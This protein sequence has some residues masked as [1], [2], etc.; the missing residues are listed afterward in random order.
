MPT[1]IRMAEHRATPGFVHFT[2]AELS[3]LLDLYAR[4]VAGGEWRDYAIDLGPERAV[5]SI[6]RHTLDRP[7]YA[8]AKLGAAADAPEP[9]RGDYVVTDSERE[10][11]RSANLSE[12]LAVLERKPRLVMP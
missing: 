10:L 11:A 4:R 9:R 1:L 6:Y 2:R 7:L 8:V 12:A 3:L 5:F